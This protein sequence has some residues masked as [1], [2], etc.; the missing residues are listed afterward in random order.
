V[1]K[2][3]ILVVLWLAAVLQAYFLAAVSGSSLM[4]QLVLLLVVW[5]ACVRGL[6]LSLLAAI[7]AGFWL[8]SLSSTN[9]GFN[10]LLFVAVVTLVWLLKR[11]GVDFSS[12]ASVLIVM[13]L[14]ILIYDMALLIGLWLDS[15]DLFWRAGLLAWLAGEVVVNLA[16][17]AVANRRLQLLL[18]PL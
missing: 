2:W 4:L 13:A 6:K 16:V 12:R 15:G 3:L 10:M 9:F 8:D 7:W 17:V 18:R 5:V 11:F 14:A 1:N